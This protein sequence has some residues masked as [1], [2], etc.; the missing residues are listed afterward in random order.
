MFIDYSNLFGRAYNPAD[1]QHNRQNYAEYISFWQKIGDTE[2]A[3]Q[4]IRSDRNDRAY[5]C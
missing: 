2:Y 5:D 4:L 1:I 3:E